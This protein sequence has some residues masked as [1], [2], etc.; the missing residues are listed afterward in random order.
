M[1]YNGDGDDDAYSYTCTAIGGESVCKHKKDNCEA[2]RND[3]D[4]NNSN[5]NYHYYNKTNS[6][7]NCLHVR[8]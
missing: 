7:S 6:R 4:N 1:K 3:D 2:K 5:N 8:V